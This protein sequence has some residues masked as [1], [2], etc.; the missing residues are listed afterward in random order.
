MVHTMYT[1]ITHKYI[2]TYIR[3][4]ISRLCLCMH[5]YI[6][7]YYIHISIL[8]VYI[9]I[10]ACVCGVYIHIL[11]NTPMHRELCFLLLVFAVLGDVPVLMG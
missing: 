9:Y 8:Y 4:D 10:V 5:V 2:H 11:P 3:T 6:Y 7:I 1:Q